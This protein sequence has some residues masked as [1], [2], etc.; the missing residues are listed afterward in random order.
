[1]IANIVN[2]DGQV[3]SLQI[4]VLNNIEVGNF[5][6]YRGVLIKNITEENVTLEVK[7]IG[8]TDYITTVFYPG[9]NVELVQSI[10][11][12]PTNTLQYGY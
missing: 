7:L 6:F 12:V 8:M 11:N 1:M 3:N 10:K 9:W 4:S 5:D 2:K